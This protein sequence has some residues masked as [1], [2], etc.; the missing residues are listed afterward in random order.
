MS[1]A[2]SI[3]AQSIAHLSFCVPPSCLISPVRTAF[4]RFKRRNPHF[5]LGSI[6]YPPSARPNRQFLNE[7]RVR[8]A[9]I[10]RYRLTEFIGTGGIQSTP[11]SPPYGTVLNVGCLISQ[12]KEKRPHLR[13]PSGPVH[14]DRI[15]AAPP[16]MN[17]VDSGASSKASSTA[18]APSTPPGIP[19]PYGRACANC[20]K[21][22]CKC[23]YRG[24]GREISSCE[25]C[26]RLGKDCVPS[27][28]V[29]RRTSRR[30]GTSRTAQLEVRY[31]P[32]VSYYVFFFPFCVVFFFHPF[33][34]GQQRNQKKNKK[35]N[36]LFRPHGDFLGS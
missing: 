1:N 9:A 10:S 32:S 3:R 17:T 29:R 34:L 35:K 6:P 15:V 12:K 22:K 23:F 14:S 8:P 36:T 33:F 5:R 30:Q 18:S 13:Y 26:H 24:N 7:S 28:T 21:A 16:R 25:R 11:P 19:A 2:P 27:E 31:I 20:V 4:T